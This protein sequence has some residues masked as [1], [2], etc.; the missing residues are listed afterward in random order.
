MLGLGFLVG[1]W[2][3]LDSFVVGVAGVDFCGLRVCLLGLRVLCFDV[4]WVS[5]G[6][7]VSCVVWRDLVWWFWAFGILVVRLFGL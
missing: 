1:F 4:V 3:C 2:I 6:L 5:A 7:W